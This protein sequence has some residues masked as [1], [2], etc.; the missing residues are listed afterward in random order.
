[1]EE[2]TKENNQQTTVTF[3]KSTNRLCV[4]VLSE[5]TSKRKWD[6]IL[7]TSR[8]LSLARMRM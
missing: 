7:K 3:I 5:V 6:G 1:V 2:R 4:G 8:N